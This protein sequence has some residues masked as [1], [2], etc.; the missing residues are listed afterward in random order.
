MAHNYI[1]FESFDEI[2]EDIVDQFGI[3]EEEFF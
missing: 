1:E 3:E 2:P